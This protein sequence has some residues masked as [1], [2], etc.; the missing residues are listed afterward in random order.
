M[1][2]GEHYFA[3]DSLRGACALL[4]AF[5]H[6][7]IYSVGP[8]DGRMTHSL[9]LFVDYFFILSGFVIALNYSNKVYDI[10]SFAYYFL[11]RSFRILPLHVFI[12]IIFAAYIVSVQML[13]ESAPYSVGASPSTYDWRKFPLVLALTNSIG[14]YSGG[15]NTPSWSISAEMIA[16]FVFG[17]IFTMRW[18]VALLLFVVSTSALY[19]FLFSGSFID[20]TVKFGF[21]RC[22]YGFGLGV[23]AAWFGVPVF[24]RIGLNLSN[25]IGEVFSIL[26]VLILLW[27]SVSSGGKATIY[28]CLAPVVFFFSILIF[29]AEKGFVSRFLILKPLIYLGKISY[30]I[31]MTHWVLFLIMSSMLNFFLR[32]KGGAYKIVHMANNDYFKI[33]LSDWRR[34]MVFGLVYAVLLVLTSSITYR[35]IEVPFVKLGGRLTGGLRLGARGHELG[36][37]LGQWG[38]Q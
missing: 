35:Y 14:F 37:A 24:D 29:S 15:W 10:R 30:S 16:Y 19:C 9:F 22:F 13:G 8:L 1:K 27:F 20:L 32:A 5:L 33:D 23:F 25:S 7:S 34:F 36:S 2:S 28:S 3:L 18:R 4:V 31:Y 38:R 21:V 26:S 6:F 12:M 11:K 17:I